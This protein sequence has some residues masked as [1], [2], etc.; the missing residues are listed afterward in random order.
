MNVHSVTRA[1]MDL[2]VEPDILPTNNPGGQISWLTIAVVGVLVAA[3]VIGVVAVKR[4][5]KRSGK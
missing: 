2:A 3:A 1:I 4:K 5:Q